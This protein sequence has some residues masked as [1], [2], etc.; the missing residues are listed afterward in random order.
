M[1]K[2]YKTSISSN[3]EEMGTSNWLPEGT[4][5]GVAGKWSGRVREKGT[6]PMGRWSWVNMQGKEDRI[7]RV[8]SSYRISQN[9]PDKAGE[10]TL[11]KQQWRSHVRRNRKRPNPR[12]LHLQELTEFINNWTGKD[13]NHQTIILMDSNEELKEGNPLHQFMTSTNL[14]DAITVLNP[15]LTNDKTYIDG[16]KRIDHIFLSPNLANIAIRAGHHQ[17]HQYVISDHKGVYVH[18][19][20]SELFGTNSCE[21]CL[22]T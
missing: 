21:N 12:E 3:M 11:C 9:N 6:D 16:N 7:I 19:R 4:M 2:Y 22:Y 15:D 8:I 5:V 13:K 1:D 17:F 14:V 18:F 10:L 20:T